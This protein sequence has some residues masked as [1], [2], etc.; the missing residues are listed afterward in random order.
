MGK[1]TLP[2]WKSF[3][4]P[5]YAGSPSEVQLFREVPCVPFVVAPGQQ[6]GAVSFAYRTEQGTPEDQSACPPPGTLA[7]LWIAN[8]FGEI[9][10]RFAPVPIES[11]VN[12][13]AVEIP[14]QWPWNPEPG[15]Y[16]ALISCTIPSGDAYTGLILKSCYG[17]VAPVDG[18]ASLPGQVPTLVG[19]RRFEY[20]TNPALD[21]LGSSWPPLETMLETHQLPLITFEET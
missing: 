21:D 15:L 17:L 14:F 8:R 9:I 16:Y 3:T 18:V 11:Q 4:A 5:I 7:R 20:E 12:F 10:A 6:F 2:G 19:Q 13:H 1:W